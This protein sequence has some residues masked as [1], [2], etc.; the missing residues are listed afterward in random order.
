MMVS[1]TKPEVW[2]AVE[3]FNDMELRKIVPA[4]TNR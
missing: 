4:K 3:C 2:K 1:L